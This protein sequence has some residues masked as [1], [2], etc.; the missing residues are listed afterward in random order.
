MLVYKG[1]NI[2]LCGSK[3][4]VEEAKK[5]TFYTHTL[6]VVRTIL[7]VKTKCNEITRNKKDA[8]TFVWQ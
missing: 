6:S 1:D 7:E 5:I 2:R 4:M 8:T 3:S